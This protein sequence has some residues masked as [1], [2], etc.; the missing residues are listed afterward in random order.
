MPLALP[1]PGSMLKVVASYLNLFL[2]TQT[3]GKTKDRFFVGVDT[4]QSLSLGTLM[5]QF[6]CSG[7]A[8]WPLMRKDVLVMLGLLCF[9]P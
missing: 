4:A 8:G 1:E 2:P 6:L 3:V 5:L 9:Q 7:P